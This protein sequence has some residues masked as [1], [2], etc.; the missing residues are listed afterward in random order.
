VGT[1]VSL[2]H[3][4][5]LDI[6]AEGVETIAQARLLNQLEC[7]YAQGFFFAK[8]LPKDEAAYLLTQNKRW[9]VE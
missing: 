4:L 7:Q 9:Q 8:P 1:I 6:I 3:R 5:K 2:G